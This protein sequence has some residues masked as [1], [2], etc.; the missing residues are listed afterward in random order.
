VV[1]TVAGVWGRAGMARHQWLL[2]VAVVAGLIGMHHLACAHAEYPTAM[3]SAAHLG[4]IDLDRAGSAAVVAL[5]AGCS[6]H[7]D[8]IGHLCLAVLTAITSL[9]AALIFAA[10]RAWSPESGH[11]LA[12]VSAGAARAPP[13]DGARFTRLCVLRS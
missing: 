7:M 12:A 5:P 13:I 8:M 10:I 6:D 11:V 9:A 2:I 3:V 1:S 4:H